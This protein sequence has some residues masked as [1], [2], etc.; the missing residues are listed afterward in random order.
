MITAT[1]VK[2]EIG[3]ILRLPK[4]FELGNVTEVEV[5]KRDNVLVLIPLR[6][7]WKSFA[8]VAQGDEDFLLNRCDVLIEGR[9]NFDA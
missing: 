7:S 1:L 5:R 4:E 3:Q 6:K 8:N 2:D 9:V